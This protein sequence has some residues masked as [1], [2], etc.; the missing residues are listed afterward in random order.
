MQNLIKTL[1]IILTHIWLFPLV[2]WNCS[3][4]Y[5]QCVSLF[6]YKRI[7][8]RAEYCPVL[9]AIDNEHNNSIMSVPWPYQ[10]FKAMYF[11]VVL[12][13]KSLTTFELRQHLLL[14]CFLTIMI[15][16]HRRSHRKYKHIDSQIIDVFD[17]SLFV[18]KR[19][20]LFM[21]RYILDFD[22]N[23]NNTPFQST[24]CWKGEMRPCSSIWKP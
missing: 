21:L 12:V 24:A 8:M 3:R 9:V 18:A 4:V 13:V 19:C 17:T 20:A 23:Y 11:L 5:A 2:H 1:T 22:I 10:Y 16:L 7:F 6:Q 15:K 14:N